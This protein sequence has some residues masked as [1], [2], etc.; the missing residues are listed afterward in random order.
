MIR[1]LGFL[2]PWTLSVLFYKVRKDVDGFLD[3]TPFLEAPEWATVKRMVAK[4]LHMIEPQ[5]PRPQVL[6]VGIHQ[7]KP[8]ESKPWTVDSPGEQSSIVFHLA[9]VTNP[10]CIMYAGQASLH[11]PSGMLAYVATEV[12][13]SAINMGETPAYHLVIE[14]KRPQVQKETVQ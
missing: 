13:N 8:K 12:P 4:A 10:L 11:M 9:V 2:D 6:G 14:V 1:P 7:L 3:L 5:G